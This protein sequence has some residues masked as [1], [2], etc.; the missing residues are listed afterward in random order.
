MSRI[1]GLKDV[2]SIEHDI[3]QTRAR[4]SHDL[5]MLDRE[6]A[7]RNMFVHALRFAGQGK[8][9]PA[10]ATAAKNNAL[11]LGLIGI[12]FA[13]IVFA[14]PD[15]AAGRRLQDALGQTWRL[16]EAA[17]GRAGSAPVEPSTD[18]PKEG[19]N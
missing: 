2:L 7:L 1:N 19:E 16:L 14:N 18:K 6:Y 12:G 15:R 5:A 3:V 11:P 9:G 10:L 4:L 13:W 17:I 8:G